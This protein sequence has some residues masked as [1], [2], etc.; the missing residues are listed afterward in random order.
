MKLKAFQTYLKK[1]GI[2]LALLLSPDSNIIY[3]TQVN[4]TAAVLTITPSNSKLYLS[5]LDKQPYIQAMDIVSLDK[6]WSKKMYDPAIK[7]VG[8]VKS[9]LTVE[10]YEKLQKTFP[11][12]QFVDVSPCLTELRRRKTKRE[13]KN[14]QKA[15]TITSQAFYSLLREL[16]Y[17]RLKT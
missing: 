4:P 6:D 15:C 3:F 5:Q 16:P 13:I 9:S 8:I 10:N 11:K 1:E 17:R 12:A 7:K 14:I 2:G